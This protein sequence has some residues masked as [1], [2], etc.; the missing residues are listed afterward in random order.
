M[1]LWCIL[2]LSKKERDAYEAVYMYY[3]IENGKILHYSYKLE[4]VLNFTLETKDAETYKLCILCEGN[5]N[6]KDK[7]IYSSNYRNGMLC[8]HKH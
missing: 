3:L 8:I 5:E 6:G 1:W 7:I 2:V 4:R